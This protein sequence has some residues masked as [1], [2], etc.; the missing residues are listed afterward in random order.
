MLAS[1]KA[2]F[3]QLMA[4]LGETFGKDVSPTLAS[5]Y[6]K[7]FTAWDLD[8]FEAAVTKAVVTLRFFPKPAE[9]IELIEGTATDHTAMAEQAWY[10]L[11][12]ALGHAGTYRSLFCED[13]VLAETIRRLFGDWPATGM[14]PRAESNDGP[15]YQVRHK[16]FVATYVRLLKAR[17]P[18]EPYLIGRTESENDV[19]A[20]A[21]F[22]QGH[23]VTYLPRSGAPEPI[24]LRAL[25]PDHPLVAL[26]EA[27]ERK[28]LKSGEDERDGR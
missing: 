24:E 5:I 13:R 28:A 12:R 4:V 7:A 22:G 18:Y 27:Q 8:T 20:L 23:Q 17:E 26:M 11:W 19:R 1:D 3:V 9:L 25:M 2:R 10:Q 6:F 15:M 14:M 16:E 21:A